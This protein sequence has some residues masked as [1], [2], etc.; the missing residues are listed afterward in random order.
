M[1]ALTP[2]HMA[3]R[4]RAIAGCFI[5]SVALISICL[6][7]N[8]KSSYSAGKSVQLPSSPMPSFFYR[9]I[10]AS[11]TLCALGGCLFFDNL[12]LDIHDSAVALYCGIA[13]TGAGIFLFVHAK[14]ALGANYSPCFDE[15]LPLSITTKGAYRYIRHPIYV[16]NLLLLFGAFVMSGSMWIALNWIVLAYFYGRAATS[17]EGELCRRLNGY[18]EYLHRTGRF[19]PLLSSIRSLRPF[20]R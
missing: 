11:T 10:Q 2:S 18:Q 20:E 1:I 4:E 5:L 12:F 15:Y 6:Y 16:S 17:E 13:I 3:L 9:Y 19:I 7:D 14:L 8:R